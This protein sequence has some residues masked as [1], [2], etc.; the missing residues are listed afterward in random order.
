MLN[1]KLKKVAA[2]LVDA[3]RHI[4][5]VKESLLDADKAWPDFQVR[6]GAKWEKCDVTPPDAWIWASNG[7]R[8][9]LIH[10]DG[11]PI[12]SSATAVRWWTCAFIPSPPSLEET[13]T[14][15]TPEELA[16]AK[17]VKLYR[18][19][20]NQDLLRLV[21]EKPM[22]QSILYDLNLFP[23]QLASQEKMTVR[24]FAAYNRLEGILLAFKAMEM[25]TDQQGVQ[26]FGTGSRT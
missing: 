11:N 12:P 1:D 2:L 8:V 5:S 10:G 16:E 9:W 24:L 23:E 6:A 15:Q 13:T 18:P 26:D 19:E 21:N 4:N 7:S 20:I 17:D 14:N 22:V 25:V 3:Q